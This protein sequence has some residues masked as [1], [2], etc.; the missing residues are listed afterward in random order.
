MEL[1]DQELSVDERRLAAELG[2][3]AEDASAERRGRIMAAVRSS[4]AP[5]R[6]VIGPWRVA[7]AGLGAVGILM[8]STGGAVAASGDALPNSPNYSLRT[9]GEQV[10][11]VV[12]NPSEREKL[13]IGFATARI[14]QAQAILAHDRANAKGLLRDS[15]QYLNQ[16]RNELGT[17]PASQ[18]GQ[19][20]SQLNQAEA[21]EHQAEAQL[22]QGGEQ[23]QQ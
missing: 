14:H 21:A 7:L 20:Q 12:A 22:N 8:A 3:L 6:A 4:N 13:R 1:D 11:L 17:V 15:R 18:Q 10:R 19:I 2:A 5:R 9:F 23:G 16:T